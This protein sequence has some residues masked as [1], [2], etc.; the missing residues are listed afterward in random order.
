MAICGHHLAVREKRETDC[1]G[2]VV[3]G[4]KDERTGLLHDHG[5]G[6]VD[7]CGELEG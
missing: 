5:A 3:G 4:S 2:G 6:A 7:G 1:G